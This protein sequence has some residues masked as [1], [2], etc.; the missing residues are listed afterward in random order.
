MTVTVS[1]RSLLTLLAG[2]GA[3][4]L[5]GC[6]PTRGAASAPAVAI[7]DPLLVHVDEGQALLRGS[8]RRTIPRAVASADGGW[9]FATAPDGPDTACWRIDTTTGAASAK[10]VLPGRWVPQVVSADGTGVALTATGTTV[11]GG[12]PAGRE[13][14]RVLVADI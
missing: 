4:A 1:R 13:V 5:A 3:A 2:A 7:P 14:T 6:E 11:N 9:I 12:R 8:D 10:T